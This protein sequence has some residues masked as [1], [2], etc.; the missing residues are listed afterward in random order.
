MV[1]RWV[2]RLEGEITKAGGMAAVTAASAQEGVNSHR[3][4]NMLVSRLAVVLWE[5][6]G[7]RQFAE[8][9]PGISMSRVSIS[10]SCPRRGALAQGESHLLGSL[11]EAGEPA[12]LGAP[13]DGGASKAHRQQPNAEQVCPLAIS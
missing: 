5:N 12:Q 6:G 2:A 1:R 11:V 7:V 9:V 10:F 8:L 4:F 13:D 3:D